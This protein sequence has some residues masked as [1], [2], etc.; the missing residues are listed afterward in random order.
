[1]DQRKPLAYAI[2]NTTSSHIAA[3]HTYSGLS[4]ATAAAGGAGR[5]KGEA[6][7]SPAS[8]GYGRASDISITTSQRPI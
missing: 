4:S 8:I 1:V 3:S 5:G 6:S 2:A 7:S